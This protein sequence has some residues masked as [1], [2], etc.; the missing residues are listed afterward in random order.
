MGSVRRL[1]LKG[2]RNIYE[3]L[4]FT[5][6]RKIDTFLRK[7]KLKLGYEDW[8]YGRQK[9]KGCG[10]P[11]YVICRYALPDTALF[12]AAIQYAFT[13][14]YFRKKGYTSV[15]DLE[16]EI[17]YGQNQLGTLDLWS[18]VFQQDVKPTDVPDDAWVYIDTINSPHAFKR[19]DCLELNGTGNDH[20][21]HARDKDWR[22]YYKKANEFVRPAW[23][24]KDEIK[25]NWEQQVRSKLD[26]SDV[27]LGVALREE[28][29]KSASTTRLAR[30]ERPQV[31]YNDHPVV[32]EVDETLLLVEKQMKL[33]KCNK[34]FISTEHWGSVELF[35]SYFGEENVLCVDR[36]FCAEHDFTMRHEDNENQLIE[37]NYYQA[38]GVQYRFPA[39]ATEVWGLSTCDYLLAAKCSGTIAALTFNGGKYKD[40]CILPDEN[41]IARY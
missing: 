1:K 6:H 38:I 15:V 21:I 32:P 30:G 23:I 37:Q 33:W 9:R 36:Y 7:K 10:K 31:V 5:F 18:C 19:Q 29:A 3:I 35:K 13:A 26:K 17:Y 39:Y 41:H 11:R 20:W 8:W 24:L 27:V 2:K 28:F 34:I 12:A 4:P 16:Y 22:D 25:Q 40:I 14:N